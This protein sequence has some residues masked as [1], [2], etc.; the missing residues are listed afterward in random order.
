MCMCVQC[1]HVPNFR[2][3]TYAIVSLNSPKHSAYMHVHVACDC[4]FCLYVWCTM[5]N[6]HPGTPTLSVGCRAWTSGSTR[7]R[8]R[9]ATHP[10]RHP[11]HRQCRRRC[12][13]H[14]RRRSHGCNTTLLLVTGGASRPVASTEASLPLLAPELP[15]PSRAGG[16]SLVQRRR[17]PQ[18][19][20]FAAPRRQQCAWIV[21][22]APLATC[23]TC[24]RLVLTYTCRAR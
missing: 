19:R 18:W 20:V 21:F 17:A 9:S 4:A 23:P 13:N 11:R 24:R 6:V 15:C 2:V 8:R 3:T 7:S 1:V 5:Y 12:C 22:A 10:R 14:C 16:T